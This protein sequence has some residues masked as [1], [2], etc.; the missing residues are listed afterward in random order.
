MDEFDQLYACLDLLRSA[1]E[2]LRE[3]EWGTEGLC[4][5]CWSGDQEVG[6]IPNH[7]PGCKLARLIANVDKV[8]ADA[9]R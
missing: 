1:V 5:C 4:P 9:P 6:V 7:A 8:L 2:E 3:H